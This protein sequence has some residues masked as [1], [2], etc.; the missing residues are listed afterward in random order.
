MEIST[1]YDRRAKDLCRQLLKILMAVEKKVKKEK[2]KKKDI[3]RTVSSGLAV[4][5]S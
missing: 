2:K 3:S 4:V 1:F 5:P